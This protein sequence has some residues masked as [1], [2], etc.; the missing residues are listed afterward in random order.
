MLIRLFANLGTVCF[1][2]NSPALGRWDLD[3]V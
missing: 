3:T 2:R 1:L